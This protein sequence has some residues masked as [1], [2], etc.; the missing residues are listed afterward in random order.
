MNLKVSVII[1]V[2]NGTAF[3]G[4]ALDSVLRQDYPAHEVIVI[5]DG[6]TDS[7]PELLKGYGDR[8]IVRRIQNSGASNA[9][10][11]GM[12]M[13]T[14]DALAFLD[15]DDVWFR[16]KLKVQTEMFGRYPQ[17]GLVSCNYAV[18]A[19]HL[20][21]RMLNHFSALQNLKE[22]N[23]NEPLKRPA[24]V[25]LVKEN[26]IGTPSAVLIKKEL[27]DAVGK[28]S[29]AHRPSEDYEYW[30]RC[31]VRANFVL[32]SQML[33]YKRTHATNLSN[34]VLKIQTSHKKVMVDT[35]RLEK[36]YIRSNKFSS[37]CSS[38]LARHNYLLGTL[39]FE[40]GDARKAFGLYKE[41]LKA[42]AS[43]YNVLMFLWILL[44]KGLRVLSG[45]KI[46]RKSYRMFRRSLGERRRQ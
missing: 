23:F 10:N 14:G 37:L 44:K 31:A 36:A 1:P 7:T 26:F 28:L 43:P 11:I 8:L 22:M 25:L 12:A 18:R 29:D 33:F 9:R 15:H 35:F 16:N 42:S 38:E 46:S 3:V 40:K 32:I 39:Y 27:S 6:S 24:F 20:K 45:E 41:G 5:D 17:A 19:H 21:G 30:L 34:D 4:K 2:Y 13:A